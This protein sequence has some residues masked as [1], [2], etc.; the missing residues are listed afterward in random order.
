MTDRPGSRRRPGRARPPQPVATA[1]VSKRATNGR[2]LVRRWRDYRS[3]QLEALADSNR[4]RRGQWDHGA[5]AA[6][7]TEPATPHATP[8]GAP[9]PHERSPSIG[10]SSGTPTNDANDTPTHTATDN[11]ATRSAG[12]PHTPPD[13]HGPPG[14]GSPFVIGFVGALGVLAAWLLA[15]TL[16]RLNSVLTFLVVAV[17]LTLVL[18]PI[19]EVLTR[20]GVRRPT[21]VF[22]VFLGLLAVFA[23][24]AGLV[25][26][27]IA[28]ESATLVE[29]APAYFEEL[30]QRRWVADLDARYDLSERLQ[31]EVDKRLADGTIVSTA[32]GGMLG[33]AGWVAGGLIGLFTA[34][35]L[36]LYFLAALPAVK[37]AAYRMVPAS[38][39]SRVISL[40]E[41]IMRRVGGYALGQ[42]GVATI[43]GT[44]SW[45]LMET[46]DIPYAV[47][48]AFA[49]ACWG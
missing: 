23:L 28:Q 15:Q 13:R 31:E 37:T 41:E 35:I 24:F 16:V 22:V 4:L 2:S 40:A 26:P 45:V 47:V 32:F 38:R 6:P 5:R 12:A 3:R 27:P 46:L 43:N 42:V 48:L 49:V 10:P 21:G 1:P 9:T 33:A 19:V 36:T 34:L 44:C 8:A 14:F 11:T 39:R 29:R 18:D 7:N 30:S 25:V 17:F 20:R